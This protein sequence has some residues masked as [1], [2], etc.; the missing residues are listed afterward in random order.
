MQEWVKQYH[1]G[2][3]NKYFVCTDDLHYAL[4]CLTGIRFYGLLPGLPRFDRCL[5]MFVHR[6]Q[7]SCLFFMRL[8]LHFSDLFILFGLLTLH[9]SAPSLLLMH[10]LLLFTGPFPVN[11]CLTFNFLSR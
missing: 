6:R 1:T 8:P 10:I 11:S 9:F 7:V 3:L 4:P 5:M 2:V